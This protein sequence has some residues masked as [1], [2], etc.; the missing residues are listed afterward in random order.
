MLLNKFCKQFLFLPLEGPLREAFG[1]NVKL[2]KELQRKDNTNFRR[3]TYRLI[4]S[5]LLVGDI[6]EICSFLPLCLT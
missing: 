4:F 2:K 3:Y 5:D 6:L 1:C